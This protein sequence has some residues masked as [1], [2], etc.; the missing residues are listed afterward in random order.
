MKANKP[1]QSSKF[2]QLISIIC[3]LW[4]TL[5]RGGVRLQSSLY[6]SINLL[7]SASLKCLYRRVIATSCLYLQSNKLLCFATGQKKDIH[8]VNQEAS[9]GQK[10]WKYSNFKLKIFITRS[11]EVASFISVQFGQGNAF[12]FTELAAFQFTD[13]CCT[14]HTK[15]MYLASYGKVACMT[16]YLPFS[17]LMF[18]LKD[19]HLSLCSKYHTS[20]LFSNERLDFHDLKKIDQKD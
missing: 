4:F 10:D 18:D 11:L 6:W 17:Q 13:T 15:S 9:V 19:H 14:V 3:W 16:L 2:V 1:C 12:S 8:R 5:R 7:L 20:M